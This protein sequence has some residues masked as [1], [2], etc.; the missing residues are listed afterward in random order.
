MELIRH[1]LPIILQFLSK[2]LSL[3]F[4]TLSLYQLE[5]EVYRAVQWFT[6]SVLEKLLESYDDHLMRQRDTRQW[7]FVHA[8]WRTILTSFGEIRFRR[9]YYR[10]NKTGKRVCLLDQ[11]L[12]LIP[13]Q[14]VSARLREHMVALATEVSYHR[15]ANILQTWVPGVSVM[16]VWQAVQ[17]VGEQE[18]QRA[19]EQQRLVFEQG[20]VPAGERQV[21][22]LAVEADSV[23]VPARRKQA[24]Q[25]RHVE[26]KLGVAYEGRTEKGRLKERRVVAGVM[27][28][29]DFWEQTVAMCSRTWDFRAVERCWLGSDGAAWLKQGME[30]LP[31][32]VYRLDRY[33]L[34]RALVEGL[35]GDSQ[36]YKQVAQAIAEGDWDNVQKGLREAWKRAGKAQQKRIRALERYLENNWEG[37]V[38]LPEAWRLGA[39]E[40][41]VFHHLA[42]RMKRHGARWSERGADH[43]A[44][45]LAVK[46]SGEWERLTVEKSERASEERVCRVMRNWGRKLA[47]AAGDWLEGN[48]PALQGTAAGRPWV[49]YVLREL[50]RVDQRLW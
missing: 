8:K 41:Q 7:R 30:V 38:K 24:G 1:L 26:V 17:R 5:E 32:A 13:R 33:H 48:M 37:I 19:E 43:L 42:R 40:G 6:C 2:I 16:T 11:A 45:V 15:A 47:R 20:E 44:R 9:R 14:R 18:R 4:Q 3:R 29:E 46:G 25:P 28:P 36:G 23:W 10:D 50:S 27:A 22:E 12:G 31:H 39:I 49:K 35:G 21:K 34:R